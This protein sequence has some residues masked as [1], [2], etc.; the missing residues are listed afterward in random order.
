MTLTARDQ[1]KNP[2]EDGAPNMRDGK[3]NYFIFPGDSGQDPKWLMGKA[4]KGRV[5]VTFTHDG[6]SYA[7]TEFDLIPHTHGAGGHGHDH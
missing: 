3:T 6:A 7:S 5:K 4:F 2:D 1:D